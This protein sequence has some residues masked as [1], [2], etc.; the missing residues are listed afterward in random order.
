MTTMMACKMEAHMVMV[1]F[2]HT[3]Y[4]L[5]HFQCYLTAMEINIQMGLVFTL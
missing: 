5:F 3:V 2:I 4:C 1:I